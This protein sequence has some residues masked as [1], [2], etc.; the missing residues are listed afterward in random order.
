MPKN[1]A[2]DRKFAD[3]PL[4]GSGFEPPVPQMHLVE[5]L[6]GAG[7]DQVFGGPISSGGMVMRSRKI[8]SHSAGSEPAGMPP[9]SLKCAQDWG[10]DDDLVH[11]PR[12][13]A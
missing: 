6:F 8:S 11:N 7:I 4:E 5:Q 3:S 12:P 2:R 10:K 9:M 1:S 13:F